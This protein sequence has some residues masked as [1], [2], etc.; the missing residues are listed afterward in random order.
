M[1]RASIIVSALLFEKAV[2][3]DYQVFRIISEINKDF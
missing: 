3:K 1:K 2:V